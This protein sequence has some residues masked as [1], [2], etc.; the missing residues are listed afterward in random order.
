MLI[1]KTMKYLLLLLSLACM[2]AGRAQN[3]QL[4]L[5]TDDFIAPGGRASMT[6]NGT[7]ATGVKYC[8]YQ[9][10]VTLPEGVGID[11]ENTRLLFIQNKT[12]NHQLEISKLSSGNVYRMLCYSSDNSALRI[13][14][15]LIMEI[16]LEAGEVSDGAYQGS[17]SNIL[18]TRT[19]AG[20][21]VAENLPNIPFTLNIATQVVVIANDYS[22]EYGEKN[23]K[24]EYTVLGGQ[25]VGKPTLSCE[26]T[27]KS[28]VGT[29]PIVVDKGTITNLNVQ[30]VNGSLN[31]TNAPLTI[32][33]GTYTITERDPMPEF[34]LTYTGFKNSETKDVL[35]TQPT[36]TCSA[37][38]TNTPGEYD[39]IVGGAKAI[40]YRFIYEQGKLII[41]PLTVFTLRYMVD[42]E[43]YKSY[44]VKE[45]EPITPEPAPVKEGYT[46]SGWSDIPAVMPHHDVTVNG[47]FT[48]NSYKLTYKVDGQVYKTL[49]LNYGAT[50]TPE[51][52]PT[53]EGYTF[54]G[55]SDIP[56]TMPAHDVT[57]TG[58]FG[59][60]TYKLSY[61]V[62]GQVYKTYQL[63]YGAE[64]TPE[65]AP[66][67]EGYTFSGWSEIPAVMPHH[68]VTVNGS[69]TVNS[70]KLTYKVDGQVYKTLTLNYGATITPEPAPTKEGYTFSGWSD[71]PATMPAHD[72]TV[73]GTFGINTYKL[74]Y[75]VDGQVY[76]T[77]QLS[78]G[79]EITPE[80]AP[81]KEG[82]TFSGW[83]EI[84]ATMPAHNVTVTGTFAVNTYRLT[85]MVDGQVYK[86]YTLN[87]G[88]TIVPE[89]DPA[90]EGY[91]FSGW[92]D[93]PAK[94]PA[95][96]VTVTGTFI[97]KKYVLTYI[98]DG[99]EYK[100]YEVEYD[101]AI[102]PEPDPVKEGY[103]FT[104]WSEIP[105][106]MPAH[107]V[108]VMGS[109]HVNHYKLTYKVAGEVYKT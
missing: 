9:F 73:T 78:Y 34:T 42:G 2:T 75:I 100:T 109:F 105:E 70:Y 21:S 76:K 106:T 18:F 28:P 96:D 32:S 89:P 80:P 69:F 40:N 60:N 52:A 30:L 1:M 48:V 61:I 23:P 27:K 41:N 24:L 11:I 19:Y 47:S 77:Y 103:S 95:H 26:A 57:V 54:S 3:I 25:L 50:I 85:Y 51:P 55:W 14:E 56:A 63:S 97:V 46:F 6:L 13:Q 12:T 5:D 101:T 87:Y 98:V 107:T 49:T 29:Y 79:A 4:S 58:T 33:A 16:R 102:T 15:N 81:T 67:K 71:I 93:I 92:S 38:D 22:R 84:P 64:I 94:M 86:T 90:K 53:K 59:I 35:L 43:L 99:Q 36:V 10:D 72:V 20:S 83:S 108:I 66:T 7:I 91:T 88:T 8:A 39:V 65:P 44:S 82:Y 68:D 31:V 17:I 104:G 74:S 62:D 45:T 37:T